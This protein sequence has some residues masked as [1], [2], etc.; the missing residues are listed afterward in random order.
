MIVRP[1]ILF[2]LATD[3]V[4]GEQE[5]CFL[6]RVIRCLPPLEGAEENTLAGELALDERITAFGGRRR[7]SLEGGNRGVGTVGG[8]AVR[9]YGDLNWVCGLQRGSGRCGSAQRSHLP[10]ES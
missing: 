7:I 4:K 2:E 5:V 1:H 8:A 6:L 3:V 10:R 9:G